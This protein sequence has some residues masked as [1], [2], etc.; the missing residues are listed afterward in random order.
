MSLLSGRATFKPFSYPDCY[1]FWLKQQKAHWLHTEV[2]LSSDVTDWRQNLTSSE[3]QLVGSVLKGFTQVEILVGDYWTQN[4]ARWFP[5][6]EV[7]MAANTMGAFESTHLAAYSLLDQTLGFDDYSAY[8]QEPTI[9]A[10]LESLM[11][12]KDM[13]NPSKE[14]MARTLAVFSAFAEGVSLFSSFAVL[15]NFSRFNKLKGVAQI[16]SWSCL[17]EGLHSEFGCYLF[18]TFIRENPEIMTDDFKK[19]IYEAARTAVALE[20]QFIDYAFSGGPVEGLDAY[21]LKQFIR[22]R[23]NVKLGDLGFKQNWKNVDKEAVDRMSWFD[24]ITAGVRHTDFFV[25]RP[26][27]YAKFDASDM[28]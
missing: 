6:P 25:Q 7:V 8:I 20:D 19:T 27:D 16:V 2:N 22:H 9:K 4:V 3:K 14:D 23:A 24:Y 26:T 15:L 12:V 11:H 10:K 21:D 28:F 1:D 13:A 5:H 17:D 18:R